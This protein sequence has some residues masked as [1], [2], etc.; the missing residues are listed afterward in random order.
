VIISKYEN[1]VVK[2]SEQ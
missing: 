1:E 2:K